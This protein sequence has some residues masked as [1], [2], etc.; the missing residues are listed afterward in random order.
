MAETLLAVLGWIV[1]ALMVGLYLGERGRRRAAERWAV[2]GLPDTGSPPPAVS[3]V[4]SE[5]AEDRFR[6]EAQAFTEEAVERGV[7]QLLEDAKAAGMT[8]DQKKLRADV[9]RMLAGEDVLD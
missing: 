5:E 6:R 7:A 8:V 4:P 2:T 1:A 3:R 9:E